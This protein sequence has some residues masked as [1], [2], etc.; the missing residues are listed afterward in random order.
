VFD[1]SHGGAIASVAT[2]GEADV[3]AAVAA[4]RRAFVEGSWPRMRPHEREALMKKAHK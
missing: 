3:D 4:A 1:P 2:A